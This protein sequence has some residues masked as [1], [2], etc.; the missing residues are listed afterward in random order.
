[1]GRGSRSLQRESGC[2]NR[3]WGEELEEGGLWG[4]GSMC[5]GA[6]CKLTGWRGV[7]VGSR[8]RGLPGA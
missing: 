7:G 6:L 8:I 2:L 5:Q 4:R 1:M 3:G